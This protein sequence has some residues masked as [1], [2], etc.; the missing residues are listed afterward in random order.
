MK[1]LRG[2][3]FGASLAVVVLL[4]TT[5]LLGS[6]AAFAAPV[7]SGVAHSNSGVLRGLSSAAGN[8]FNAKNRSFDFSR[9]DGRVILPGPQ[10]FRKEFGDVRFQMQ[11]SETPAA[12]PMPEPSTIVLLATGLLGMAIGIRRIH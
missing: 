12:Q 7:H 6:R 2:F 8:S 9:G 4:G 3:S 11:T 5:A 1:K 10:A